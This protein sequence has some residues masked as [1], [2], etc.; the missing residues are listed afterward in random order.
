MSTDNKSNALRFIC[1]VKTPIG[2]LVALYNN[3]RIVRVLFP[4]ETISAQYQMYDDS[5]PFSR[6]MIEYFE[7]KRQQF[8]LPIEITGTPFMQSVYRAALQI[9]Y[10]TTLS[11]SALA[12]KAG[13][14]LAA[15]A[16]GTALKRIKLPILIP[17]HR[18]V[19]KNS[20]KFKYRGGADTKKYLLNMESSYIRNK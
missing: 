17:C 12:L 5:L 1:R 8:L 14:P 6:Q 15:R 7:G 4:D 18:V 2:V 10:G 20:S 16:V 19:H 13:Y 9:P 11:Y 3:E